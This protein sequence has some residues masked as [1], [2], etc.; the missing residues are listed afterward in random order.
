[1]V[2]FDELISATEYLTVYTRCRIVVS[3]TDPMR[4]YHGF[5]SPGWTE[6]GTQLKPGVGQATHTLSRII[7]CFI[8]KSKV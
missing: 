3:V 6:L 1:M 5:C 4:T 7:L 2:N 8:G